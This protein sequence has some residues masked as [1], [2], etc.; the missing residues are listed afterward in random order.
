[1][2]QKYNNPQNLATIWLM[3]IFSLIIVIS[4]EV[5]YRWFLVIGW[6]FIMS[7]HL[8]MVLFGTEKLET[9]KGII[10]LF[11]MSLILYPQSYLSGLAIYFTGVM[12]TLFDDGGK[13]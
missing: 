11:M 9:V 10:I 5:I 2:Q 3:S 1:M 6:N 12:K 8:N 7:N 4:L 13:Q